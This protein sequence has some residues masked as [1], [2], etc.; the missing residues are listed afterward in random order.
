SRAIA[1]LSRT[2]LYSLRA[3]AASVPLST[4]FIDCPDRVFLRIMLYL[5]VVDRIAV[6]YACKLL[7]A[8]SLAMAELWSKV[9]IRTSDPIYNDRRAAMLQSRAAQLATACTLL[10]RRHP[11][12][13]TVFFGS[14][15]ISNWSQTMTQ[16]MGTVVEHATFLCLHAF[17]L[18]LPARF[19]LHL[20]TTD[21]PGLYTLLRSLPQ[22]K[23]WTRFFGS[24]MLPAP[25]LE[26][27][28]VAAWTFDS[29]RPNAAVL[30]QHLLG[31]VSNALKRVIL[32]GNLPLSLGGYPAFSSLTMFDWI[33]SP[34]KISTHEIDDILLHMPLLE[35]LG[36]RIKRLI[37]DRRDPNAR[38][39]RRLRSVLLELYHIDREDRI[40]LPVRH[41]QE[42][43]LP[44][45]RYI[46][47]DLA[48]GGSN[49]FDSWKDLPEP[50]CT[51]ESIQIV[52]G[53]LFA[54]GLQWRVVAP[55]YVRL[56]PPLTDLAMF[57]RLVELTLQELLWECNSGTAPFPR[58]PCLRRLCIEI[59]PC[60]GFWRSHEETEGIFVAAAL[61]DTPW[62][63]PALEHLELG[64][65]PAGITCF[66]AAHH[67]GGCTVSCHEGGVLA[68]SDVSLFVRSSLVFDRNRLKRISLTG[69]R[70]IADDE[71]GMAYLDLESLTDE[72]EITSKWSDE[73]VDL[74]RKW[75]WRLSEDAEASAP[76]AEPE[77][78]PGAGTR[79]L[80]VFTAESLLNDASRYF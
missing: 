6:S 72:L 78:R 28:Q 11:T 42:C 4:R 7:R 60:S 39:H 66:R 79:P 56:S 12:L 23:E 17:V 31:G 2:L 80:P 52:N 27:L 69:V 25:H 22:K 45:T 16:L 15:D 65:S 30:P 5:P 13:P 26:T 43:T 38:V 63:T 8:R 53:Q 50:L 75:Q 1:S 40:T 70:A 47:V 32:R 49:P 34:A 3:S 18:R 21:I 55:C 44:E 35:V 54:Y 58:A 14:M 20:A 67:L 61:I 29:R 77:F 76:T 62:L 36:L 68:M 74:G 57:E 33:P 51:P 59:F 37:E 41:F 48:W 19:D 64:F 71:P 73:L 10:R 46:S 9:A 24:F